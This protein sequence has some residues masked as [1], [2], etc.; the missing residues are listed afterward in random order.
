MGTHSYGSGGN[1]RYSNDYVTDSRQASM[2]YPS[3]SLGTPPVSGPT[4][5]PGGGDYEVPRT[6]GNYSLYVVAQGVSPAPQPLDSNPPGLSHVDVSPWASSTE[7]S[8]STT[9][10]VDHVRNRR[11]DSSWVPRPNSPLMDWAPSSM[12][13]PNAPPAVSAVEHGTLDALAPRYYYST[14][15]PSPH[16]AQTTHHQHHHSGGGGYGFLGVPVATGYP[17]SDAMM[18]DPS[19]HSH[20]SSVRSPSPITTST[21]SAESLVTPAPALPGRINLMGALSRQK[22]MA[23]DVADMSSDMYGG[24]GGGGLGF[25]SADG[26][27][28]LTVQGGGGCGGGG[29][30]IV[31]AARPMPLPSTVWKAIPGYL[32]V[33]WQRFHPTFPIVHRPTFEAASGGDGVLRCAM[34]AAATQF[35]DGNEDRIRGNL[36]HEFAWQEVKRVRKKTNP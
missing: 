17:D 2:M 36:L 34:A 30:G 13:Y 16:V 3:S 23:V 1:T 10:A 18:G 31:M 22:E 25:G 20:P 33:Y 14:V 4:S 29:G 28:V 26:G 11:L 24:G 15:H 8:Y 21:V 6:P 32:D 35:L 9:P 27:V 5:L 12:I 19:S 7:S